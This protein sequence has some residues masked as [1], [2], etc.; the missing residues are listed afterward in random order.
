MH[1]AGI[2]E[3]REGEID[4]S[5]GEELWAFDPH[6]AEGRGSENTW[7]SI[8]LQPAVEVYLSLIVPAYSRYLV[9]I[10]WT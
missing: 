6:I 1:V 7:A 9:E 4:L 3:R 8:Y 10:S 5:A 2:A